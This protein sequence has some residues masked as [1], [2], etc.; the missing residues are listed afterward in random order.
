MEQASIAIFLSFH[1]LSR[2]KGSLQ[3]G[4]DHIGNLSMNGVSIGALTILADDAFARSFLLNQRCRTRFARLHETEMQGAGDESIGGRGRRQILGQI[5]RVLVGGG[6]IR[7]GGGLLVDIL[8]RSEHE[9]WHADGRE[10]LRRKAAS[11]AEVKQ[12]LSPLAGERLR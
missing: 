12:T 7:F 6:D 10:A 3:E 5:G 11:W 9:S 1:D 4:D 2:W 8:G